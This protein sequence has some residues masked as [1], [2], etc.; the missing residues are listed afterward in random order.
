M[1]F[2]LSGGTVLKTGM[3]RYHFIGSGTLPEIT[4][5][6]HSLACNPQMQVKVESCKEEAMYERPRLLWAKAHLKLCEAKWKTVLW[7][8]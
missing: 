3:I 5:C 8:Q 1:I 6:E 2:R 7:S 4:V